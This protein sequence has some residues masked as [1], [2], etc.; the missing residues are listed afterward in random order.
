MKVVL[1]CGGYGMRMRNSA[2][3]GVPKPMQ[4]VGPRPLIWHVM[5]YYAHFGHK[6]FIL[7]LGYGAS[8]IK[9]YFLTYQEA[10][11]ND[12]VMRGSQIELTHS[13]ISDWSITFV[14]T[15]LESAIG[16]RL[17][18]VRSHLD[19]DEYFLANYADV[20]TDAPMDHIVEKFH[21]SGAAASMLIV[22]PQSSFHCVE[23]KDNGEV[24]AIVP[25]SDLAIGVNGGY[26]VLS[27][28][29]F[30]LL[31]PGGDLV[32]DVCGALA[33][34]GRLFGYR[35]GGFWKPA[36]TFKERAELDAGYHHGDRPWMVWEHAADQSE[37]DT[38]VESR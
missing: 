2:D 36:D 13:D 31:P 17:R 6:D 23:M 3:D 35:Y 1:F 32:A 33:G 10:A 27:Q 7:C 34:Q 14:D 30:D 16:E 25:V 37:L 8:H 29:I 11:S 38:P 26:F 12:F 22:P 19:G 4:M 9:N 18:R 28:E 15:G 20:L 24:K 21:E 5:R